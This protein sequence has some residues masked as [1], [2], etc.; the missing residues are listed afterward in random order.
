M[1]LPTTYLGALLLMVFSMLCWGSWANTQKATSNWR[2]ELYYYDYALGV[3]LC[4]VIVAFTFGTLNPAELTFQDNFIIAGYRKMAW[5]V[6]AGFVF[7]LAN[8][9]LVAGIS[10]AGMS[11]AFPIGIGLALVIGVVWNYILTPQGNPLLLFGGVALVVLAIVFDGIAYAAHAASKREAELEKPHP[12]EPAPKLDP[13]TGRA[14]GKAAPAPKP[15]TP[16]AIRGIIFCVLGGILMGGFYPLVELGKTGDG[17]VSPYGIAL[18]FA[19]GVFFS[20][21]IYNPFFMNFP[22]QGMPIGIGAFFRST[23]REHLMGILGGVIWCAGAISNFVASSSAASAS[24][25]PAISYAMG[26]GAALVSAL[27]GILVWK[28]FAG[29]NARV[30]AFVTAMIVLFIAGLTLVSIAPLYP[31]NR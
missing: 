10:V 21:F 6:L 30:K 5:G 15:R 3:V 8:M 25:G 24:V 17:A 29:A 23:R 16:S 1:I 19:A 7:N 20:T 27:W 13:R 14:Y 18:L 12:V 28:E 4:S 2:F 26:Q 22:I 11:V 9:L 31:V